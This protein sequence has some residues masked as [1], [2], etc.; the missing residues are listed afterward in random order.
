MSKPCYMWWS[1]PRVTA[2]P[3]YFLG[4]RFN[5]SG[6]RSQCS[7]LPCTHATLIQCVLTKE[8]DLH[9]DS[10]SATQP[11]LLLNL[12][13]PPYKYTPPFHWENFSTL[14]CAAVS[15]K[16]VTISLRSPHTCRSLSAINRFTIWWPQLP[17]CHISCVWNSAQISRSTIGSSGS[18]NAYAHFDFER[19]QIETVFSQLRIR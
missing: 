7:G 12:N 10:G 5:M 2:T 8:G 15:T 6:K 3:Q 4:K 13:H 9:P 14:C 17:C 19:L 18:S 11:P 16:Y 1:W